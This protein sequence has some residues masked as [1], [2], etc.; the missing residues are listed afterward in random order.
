MS[1]FKSLDEMREFLAEEIMLTNEAVQFLGITSQRLHQLVKSGKI[2][3]IKSQRG[4]TV[5][6][7]KDLELR[8]KELLNMNKKPLGLKKLYR[9][10]S[11]AVVQEAINYFAVYTLCNYSIKKTN[12]IFNKLGKYFD[13]SESL[14][15]KINEVSKIIGMDLSVIERSFMNVMKGFELLKEED[16]IV[17]KG[18]DLY[19]SLLAKT[20]QA[21]LFLFMRGNVRLAH[22]PTVAVVGTRNPTEE[23]EKRAYLLSALLGKYRIVVASGLARGIDRAAHKGA[24]DYNNP[25][26]AVIGTPLTKVYPKEHSLLQEEIAE[27]GL[28]ISQFP[29]SSP[30][31]RW[32]FPLRN[33]VMSGL[34]LATIVVE[35]GETSGSLVQADY[36][37]KQGRL[38]L[39]PKSAVD[40][41]KLQWPRKF[42]LRGAH[43]FSKIDQLLQILHQSNI[44]KFEDKDEPNFKVS[45][46]KEGSVIYVHKRE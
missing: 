8:K 17:K 34:S 42:L 43:Q 21:P 30:V 16:Y 6:L 1:Y 45:E 36:A 28:V 20:Q 44:I 4:G 25:T 24:L 9:V 7:K 29:P 5:F 12:E 22:L 31:H 40:N 39:I 11:Y 19:P 27:K 46:V 41:E 2:R 35:A 33:A 26:I 38:V 3:P 14:A 15:G 18:H 37:L 10:N 32:H 23:G 13:L